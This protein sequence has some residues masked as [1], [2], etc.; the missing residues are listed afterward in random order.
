MYEAIRTTSKLTND[1]QQ[2][3]KKAH[4]PFVLYLHETRTIH[5]EVY[6]TNSLKSMYIY[7]LIA[8]KKVRDGISEQC[9]FRSMFTSAQS[10]HNI[11]KLVEIYKLT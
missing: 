10:Y 9:M 6:R 1:D 5:N 3:P 7:V 2:M 4:W 8:W 11:Y